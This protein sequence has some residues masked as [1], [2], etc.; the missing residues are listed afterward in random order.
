MGAAVI[1]PTALTVEAV[2]T[3]E[4]LEELR[5][6][7]L[8][9]WLRCPE[10]TPFQSPAWLIAWWK[11]LG[12]GQLW[13]LSL[14]QDQRLVGVVPWF[15]QQAPDSLSRRVLFLGTGLSDYHDALL[16]PEFTAESCAA[17]LAYLQANRSRW[18]ACD[19]QQ[20]RRAS[21]LL[22]TELPP[23]WSSQQT[24]QDVCPVL[25]LPEQL[26]R[27][28]L[29]VPSHMRENLRYYRRRLE[30]LPAVRMEQ[31]ST[32]SFPELLENFLQLHRAR[33]AARAQS[34]VL[35]D[36]RLQAFHRE[37]AKGLLAS[38][39]LRLYG[40]RVGERLAASLYGF[41]HG[42]R[43]FFYLSGFEPSFASFSPG[44]LMV[45]HAIEQAVREGIR[46]FDFLR[47]REA[48]KFLWGAKGR[49]NYRCQWWHLASTAVCL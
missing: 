44:T 34:G 42:V 29:A 36:S 17:V 13:V 1:T 25:E 8:E 3:S 31:A 27:L 43:T 23:G 32:D 33:W 21:P 26:E 45:G 40:L 28:S 15:I 39:S 7:W 9:L 2:T 46:E 11:H 12:Q 5:A 10:A 47:G 38:G 30:K 22:Q 49:L 41:N 6:E 16:E 18:D 4:A 19:L 14:R 24:A 35:A 37:A 20:L 48:Y